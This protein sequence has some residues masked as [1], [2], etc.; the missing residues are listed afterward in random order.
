MTALF[1]GYNINVRPAEDKSLPVDV[2]FGIAYTQVVDLVSTSRGGRRGGGGGGVDCVHLSGPCS[3][4][5]LIRVI[6]AVLFS[7][8]EGAS[9]VQ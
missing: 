5:V 9:A 4:C 7:G 3:P 1:K 2:K 6:S 8:R